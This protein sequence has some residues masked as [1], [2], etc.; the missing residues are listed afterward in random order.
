MKIR[1]TCNKVRYIILLEGMVKSGDENIF[2]TNDPNILTNR[3]FIF[4]DVSKPHIDLTFLFPDQ[5]IFIHYFLTIQFHFFHYGLLFLQKMHV[6]QN[7]PFYAKV[8]VICAWQKNL[9]PHYVQC[10]LECLRFWRITMIYE[11]IEGI[12]KWVEG[13]S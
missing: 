9:C 10:R 12:C 7:F 11:H 8:N 13:E 5:P 3:L 1:Y 2:W 6:S 4:S